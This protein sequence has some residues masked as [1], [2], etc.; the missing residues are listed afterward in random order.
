[1]AI[2]GRPALLFLDE[3]TAALDVEGRRRFWQ[4]VR[5]LADEGTTVLF[6]T[7]YLEEADQFADRIVVLNH[8]R[9][10]I[11]GPPSTVKAQAGARTVRFTSTEPDLARIAALPG[12]IDLQQRGH[13]LSLRTSD[14]DAT[15]AALY[16]S[17]CLVHDLEVAGAD[18][19]EALV[20]LTGS[21]A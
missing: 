1:M 4:V 14:A 5:T 2:A 16:A 13:E 6:A 21:D 12:V 3:P 17:G 20:A 19:D 10:V 11:D 8:G 7:Q 18:L 9:V 15:V